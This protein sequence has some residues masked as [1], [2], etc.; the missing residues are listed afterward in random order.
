MGE[1]IAIKDN[2]F[3]KGTSFAAIAGFLLYNILSTSTNFDEVVKTY[4]EFPK[5]GYADEDE[6]DE[7]KTIKFMQQWMGHTWYFVRQIVLLYVWML[8]SLV[9]TF[10]VLVVFQAIVLFVVKFDTNVFSK[11][12]DPSSDV[13]LQMSKD[14]VESSKRTILPS[15]IYHMIFSIFHDPQGQLFILKLFISNILTSIVFAFFVASPKR[16]QSAKSKRTNTRLFFTTLLSQ[17]VLVYILHFI[18][19]SQ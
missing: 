14:A 8:I 18:A 7:N 15:D 19:T 11:L 2:D 17:T 4:P 12:S 10:M 6:D 1:Y 16:M 5:D 9:L 3:R 13:L